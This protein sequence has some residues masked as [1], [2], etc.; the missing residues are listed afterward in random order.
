MKP[1]ESFRHILKRVCMCRRDEPLTTSE[2]VIMWFL[3]MMSISLHLITASASTAY[4]IR[5]I[6]TD[7]VACLNCVFQFA[8]GV[9][10][11][12]AMITKFVL[13]RKV[14]VMFDKLA[15]IYDMCKIKLFV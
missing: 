11:L 2:S 8:A 7:L 10:V 13:R 12:T 5:F 3:F 14:D 9:S 6:S 1:L 4:F 15:D